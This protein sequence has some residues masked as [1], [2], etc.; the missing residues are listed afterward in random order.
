MKSAVYAGAMILWFICSVALICQ[1]INY[2]ENKMR[3]IWLVGASFILFVSVFAAC[4]SKENLEQQK[5][6]A[7]A[8]RNL[9]EAY[10][11]QANYTA[12][13]RELIKAEAMNPEDYFVQDDL[14]LAY[15]YKGDPDKAIY[16]F[17]KALAI[18]DDYGPAR[19]NLGNAY[20]EKKEWDQA[21]E[22][23][24]IVTSDLLYATPQFPYSNLGLAYYHK[25]EYR[26]SEKYFKE[27]LKITPTFDRAL[28]GLSRTYI[29]TGRVSQAVERLEFAVDKN[30][31]NKSLL[32]ELAKAYEL[33]RDY[34]RAYGA[35]IRIVQMD[36]DSPLADRALKAAH[37]IKPFL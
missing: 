26:L 32:F 31:E 2:E 17:K 20:A 29:A 25:K 27:A 10:L 3:K 1:S 13:L 24:K 8:H 4:T 6:Q 37:R 18:K 7:V 30:P 22:Q 23:Y 12:A 14:G 5:E 21:I 16:H 28:W 15:F 19:N 34:R 9:G 33:K 36:P 11:R 35:Y